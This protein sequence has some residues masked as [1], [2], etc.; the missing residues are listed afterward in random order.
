MSDSNAFVGNNNV[1]PIGTMIYWAGKTAYK[2]IVKNFL[3]C[4]GRTLNKSDYPEL[5]TA[6]GG[7]FGQTAST[8]DLPLLSNQLLIAGASGDAGS[9]EPATRNAFAT[10]TFTIENENQLPPFGLDYTASSYTGSHNFYDSTG[11][12]INLYTDS[13]TQGRDTFDVDFKYLRD[14]V[15]YQND[16]GMGTQPSNPQI[17]FDTGSD[18]D[19]IDITGDISA[20][21]S[22]TAPTFNIM[23]L[24]RVKNE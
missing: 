3:P 10:A 20:P 21:A 7:T 5:Y 11:N 23:M 14:N 15:T 8:F 24:I 13:N 2:E 16:A 22:Y 6:I 9:V 18:P 4:D 17:T 12:N 19:P 1:C